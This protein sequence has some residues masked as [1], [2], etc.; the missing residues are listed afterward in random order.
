[1]H[2]NPFSVRALPYTTHGDSSFT[3]L[4]SHEPTPNDE[5]VT[6]HW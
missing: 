4:Y 3:K 2:G 1:M 6:E 5:A